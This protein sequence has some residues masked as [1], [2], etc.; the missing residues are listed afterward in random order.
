MSLFA[1]TMRDKARAAICCVSIAQAARPCRPGRA[2]PQPRHAN[3]RTTTQ[4]K[5]ILACNAVVA[6]KSRR[7]GMAPAQNNHGV[8]I[9][10]TKY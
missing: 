7:H 8:F 9:A 4:N 3:L 6:G 5:P 10:E 1:I 2:I